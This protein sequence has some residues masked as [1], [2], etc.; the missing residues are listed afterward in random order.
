MRRTWIADLWVIVAFQMVLFFVMFILGWGVAENCAAERVAACKER[1]NQLS[2]GAIGTGATC[3]GRFRRQ[4]QVRVFCT[5]TSRRPA[6]IRG[7]VLSLALGRV[8]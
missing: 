2:W 4:S 6:V 7:A 5:A 8:A 1:V 3:V